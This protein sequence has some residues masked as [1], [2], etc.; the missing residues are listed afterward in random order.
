MY[1]LLILIIM[2]I[3]IVVFSVYVAFLFDGNHSFGVFLSAYGVFLILLTVLVMPLREFTK[4][5]E[6]NPNANING[7]YES[8]SLFTQHPT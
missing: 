3:E 6:L 7:T 2:L 1:H 4:I 8:T 5:D